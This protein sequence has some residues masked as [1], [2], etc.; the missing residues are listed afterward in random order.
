MIMNI[1]IVII[2][3]ITRMVIINRVTVTAGLSYRR[4]RFVRTVSWLR[5]TWHYPKQRP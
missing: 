1:I 3:I 5:A 2:V 4:G